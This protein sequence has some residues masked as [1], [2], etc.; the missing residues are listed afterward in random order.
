MA[1][2]CDRGVYSIRSDGF[3]GWS[4]YYN[5]EYIRAYASV[6]SAKKA[7]ESHQKKVVDNVGDERK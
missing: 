6:G 3:D 2:A 1:V 4:L 7:A 5:S